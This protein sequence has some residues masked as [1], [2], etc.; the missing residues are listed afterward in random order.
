L[1]LR[2]HVNLIV[3][4]L[5]AAFVILA[6]WLQF[7]GTRRSVREEIAGAN[8][9]ATQLMTRIVVSYNAADDRELL[10]FLQQL[11]RVRAHE[12]TLRAADGQVLYRSPPS[13]YKVGREAPGWFASRILSNPP[14]HKFLLGNGAEVIVEANAS[15]AILDGWDDLTQLMIYGGIAFAVLN[16]AVFWLVGRAVAPWPVIV[17]GLSRIE[18]GDLR[19][20]L[21]PLRG[22]EANMIGATF[23]SMAASLEDKLLS[24]RKAF[25]AE[26]RLQQRRELDQ[27]VEQRLDEERRLIARELHDEFAQS[28][29]AIRSFAVVIANQHPAE[30]RT[31]EV[32]KLISTEAARLYDAMHGLIPRLAPL[33]LDT[34]GLAE[35]LEGFIKQWQ[36]RHPGIRFS[37]RYELATQ[38]G[39][40][41]TI[42]IYRVVQEAVINAVRHA[43]PSTVEV[44]VLCSDSKAQVRVIDDGIGLPPEWSLP[45]HFGLRGLQER[46]AMLG[47]ALTLAPHDPHGVELTAE[48]PLGARS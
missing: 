5:S 38:L 4:S 29:T 39:D 32:A 8:V 11:G 42:A 46:M 25:D 16:A 22:H 10:N 1:K 15:R 2:T 20:R 35:T 30:S 36:G 7:D 6:A 9:V 41:I 43:R 21:P 47:G 34:L 3:A 31:A 18:Q 33:T 19:H 14:V 12:I 40:S 23:N 37:L 45:G 27:I 17:D 24:D 28:V 44:N 48:I 13:P 26:Q